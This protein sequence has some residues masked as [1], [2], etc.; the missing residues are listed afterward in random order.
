MQISEVSEYDLADFVAQEVE[1]EVVPK[2]SLSA[3]ELISG[4]VG[5]FAPNYPVSVPLWLALYFRQTHMCSVQFPEWLSVAGVREAVTRERES[6]DFLK[7]PNEFFEVSHQLLKFAHA[8]A[9]DA[10]ELHR[11]VSELFSVRSQKIRRNLDV[12]EKHGLHLP[13]LKL[14]NLTRVEIVS[15]RSAMAHVMDIANNLTRRGAPRPLPPAT[16]QRLGMDSTQETGA[17][18]LFTDTATMFTTEDGAGG[19]GGTSLPATT[20]ASTSQQ[21]AQPTKRRRTLRQR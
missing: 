7:L 15:L 6:A 5:P 17:E 19:V 21:L 9:E 18:G 3:I 20:E 12:L 16:N 1:V 14:T 10:V 2:F 11:L 8:D 4:T 13:G